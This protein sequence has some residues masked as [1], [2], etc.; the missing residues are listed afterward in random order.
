MLELFVQIKQLGKRKPMIAREP[1]T[2]PEG[3]G[4]LRELVTEI[5]RQRVAAFNEKKEE[6]NW[7]KYLY[8]FDLEKTAESG[9]VGFDAKYNAKTQDPDKAVDAALL[10]FEDGLFRVFLD[11]NEIE[12]LD[13]AVEFRKGQTLT[14]LRLTMLAGRSW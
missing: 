11:E 9:K 6:G 3:I 5:V 4:T 1:L 14:F 12:S 8:D 7:A 13:A 2:L 10:A